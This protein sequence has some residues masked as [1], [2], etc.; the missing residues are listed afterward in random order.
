MREANA[1]AAA[2]HTLNERL[3]LKEN[4]T[5]KLKTFFGRATFGLYKGGARE[6]TELDD[7]ISAY[8]TH[9]RNALI[10]GWGLAVAAAV[11]LLFG[12][13]QKARGFQNSI[14]MHLLSISLLFLA[15]G[16]FTPVFSLVVSQNVPV[17]KQVVLKQDSKGVLDTIA[18]L[19]KAGQAF[20]ALLLLIFSVV[21][22]LLK[23]I[24]TF[25][26]LNG[27]DH[28]GRLGKFV[29]TVGKWS[30]AD[31]FV[32]ALLLAVFSLGSDGLTDARLGIGLYFFAGYVLLS[33]LATQFIVQPK[34]ETELREQTRL[35]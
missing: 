2:S 8:T 5:I 19:F 17:L 20:V 6:S 24:L 35:A 16:L 3:A 34:L 26:V 14:S 33:L 11:I 32:V 9:R 1:A 23:T 22:P 27:R 15:I 31:V 29:K 28:S 7:V 18:T 13:F 12:Y 4:A 30:M 21:T 25:V 10:A